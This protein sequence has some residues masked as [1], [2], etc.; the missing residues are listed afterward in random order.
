MGNRCDPA[1][2]SPSLGHAEKS[3]A[4]LADCHRRAVPKQKT[5]EAANGFGSFVALFHFVVQKPAS[6]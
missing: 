1:D 6:H 5:S 4:K 3:A 2:E